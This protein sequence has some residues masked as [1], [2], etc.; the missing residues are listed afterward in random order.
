MHGKEDY[1]YTTKLSKKIKS[2]IIGKKINCHVSTCITCNEQNLR[3]TRYAHLH[4]FMAKKPFGE[5]NT[6]F[7]G[8]K[9]ST[10]N[11][12]K[13]TPIDIN[14]LSGFVIAIPL[15]NKGAD[16]ITTACLKS[17]VSVLG[18]PTFHICRQLSL[19]NGTFQNVADILGCHHEFSSPY[20]PKEILE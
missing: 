4:Y 15:P 8:E 11:G 1:T 10:Q 2:T 6:Y 3:L 19:K 13:F 9:Q 20:Y 17:A 5:I 14:Q 16:T 12:N 7:V 18:S